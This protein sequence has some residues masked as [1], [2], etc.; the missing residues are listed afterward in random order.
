MTIRTSIF[1]MTF[2][3]VAGIGCVADEAPA[4]TINDSAN[5]EIE[6]AQP[7][8]EVPLCSRC[9]LSK[10]GGY[11][12]GD[13]KLS[14][15]IDNSYNGNVTGVMLT[16]WNSAGTPS[17]HY[18]GSSVVDDI[19]DPYTEITVAY[20]EAPTATSAQLTWTHT[21]GTQLNSIAVF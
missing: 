18:F 5:L 7:Q 4:S 14:M 13:D 12:A 2:A 11:T 19:N 20:V 8:P 1:T 3:L 15:D 21:G 17:Y 6:F 9:N 16:T 10:T